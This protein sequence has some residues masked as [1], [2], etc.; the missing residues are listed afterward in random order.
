MTAKQSFPI[1]S[2]AFIVCF[3]GIISLPLVTMPF[4]WLTVES[5]EKRSANAWPTFSDLFSDSYPSV[6]RRF[7]DAF[8]DRFGMRIEMSRLFKQSLFH[9]N[10][11]GSSRT[12]VVQGKKGWQFYTSSGYEDTLQ[13][14]SGGLD[15]GES[16]LSRMTETLLVWQNWLEERGARFYYLSL[17]N[18][19]SVYS[20]YKPDYLD[21]NPNGTRTEKLLF[22]LQKAGVRVLSPVDVLQALSKESDLLYFKW[23]THWTL[24]GCYH[25]HLD[26]LEALADDFPS[27]ANYERPIYTFDVGTKYGGDLVDMLGIG[28][29][30]R[31]HLV[32]VFLDGKPLPNI[33]EQVPLSYGDRVTLKWG[34]PS[35]PTAMIF[36]DSFMLSMG[37]F[38][39]M[40]FGETTY[41]F[42]DKLDS[43]LI[44]SEGPDIVIF[45]QVERFAHQLLELPLP[46]LE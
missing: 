36:H 12:Q 45:E 22:H 15:F 10:L 7:E 21:K 2:L 42:D 5:A 37:S 30:H 23:D 26:T 9:L 4:S 31:D 33:Q 6:P 40:N 8:N 46:P 32:S 14:Y 43:A 39:S 1:L 44:E 27:L 20:Q 28:G 38:L 25:A 19:V 17:P 11:M 24:L 3:V 34:D 29:T 35:L 16:E 13:I 41:V 18:K